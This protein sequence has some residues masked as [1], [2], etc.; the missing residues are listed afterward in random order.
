MFG[1]QT[2]C[3]KGACLIQFSGVGSDS[4]SSP[5][6][7]YTSHYSRV[8]LLFQNT[9]KIYQPQSKAPLNSTNDSQIPLQRTLVPCAS[10][11]PIFFSM[12]YSSI[13]STSVL[14]KPRYGRPIAQGDFEHA[15]H[16]PFLRGMRK[17]GLTNGDLWWLWLLASRKTKT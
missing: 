7:S 10:S 5:P 11:W 13:P 17:A 2:D 14:Q 8:Y 3:C 6:K 4:Q 9:T 1:Q 12:C 15:Q 16:R